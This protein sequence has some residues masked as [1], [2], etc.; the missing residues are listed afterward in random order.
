MCGLLLFSSPVLAADPAPATEATVQQ[1]LE[2]TRTREM[3]D[4]VHVQMEAMF[5]TSID[6]AFGDDATPAEREEARQFMR[7]MTEL[8]KREMSWDAMRQM[9]VDVYRK[10]FSEEEATGMLD[11]YRTDIGQAVI[12]KM[13]LVMQHTMQAVQQHIAVIV[14]R[15]QRMQDERIEQMKKRRDERR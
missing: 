14:P 13:P 1:L 5:Q 12:A 4:Q 10:S 6:Q 15:M 9:Y 2:I 3:L 7:E 11:F 8:L